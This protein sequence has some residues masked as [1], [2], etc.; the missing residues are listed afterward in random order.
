MCRLRI[1]AL[2]TL[3]AQGGDDK[4]AS[5]LHALL[6]PK[7]RAHPAGKRVGLLAC[8]C[9]LVSRLASL[10]CRLGQRWEP[11]C[12]VRPSLEP[13][14]ASRPPPTPQTGTDGREEPSRPDSAQS[15]AGEPPTQGP[16]AASPAGSAGLPQQRP[17]STAAPAESVGSCSPSSDSTPACSS[18]DSAACSAA[19]ARPG[20]EDG[21]ASAA[22]LPAPPHPLLPGLLAADSRVQRLRLTL[23]RAPSSSDDPTTASSQQAAATDVQVLVVPASV[24]HAAAADAYAPSSGGAAAASACRKRKAGELEAAEPA[25]QAT[26]PGDLHAALAVALG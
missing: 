17:C 24:W 19:A 4:W 21:R 16:P 1:P 5:E 6:R 11:G 9:R 15:A 3:P 14:T 26:V 23:P 10:V 8:P 22:P 13:C 18:T 7:G 20:A 12:L 25:W 2:P